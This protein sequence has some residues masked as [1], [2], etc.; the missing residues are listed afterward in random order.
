MN[1]HEGR[2]GNANIVLYNGNGANIGHTLW[3]IGRI[4]C[5]CVVCGTD[6]GDVIGISQ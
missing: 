3:W 1:V 5:N 2:G 4:G 6:G